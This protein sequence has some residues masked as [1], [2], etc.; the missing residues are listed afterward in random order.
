MAL[1]QNG[2]LQNQLPVHWRTGLQGCSRQA[3]GKGDSLNQSSTF[4]QLASTPDANAPPTTWIMPRKSGKISSRSLLLGAGG[5]TP[6]AMTEGRN[7]GA[8]LSG[9][10][11]MTGVA[12]LIISM[13]ASLT[14]NGVVIGAAQGFLQLAA[15]LAGSGNVSGSVKALANA[16]ASLDGQ[17]QLQST[18]KALGR[19][20]GSINVT[21]DVLTSANVA[22]SIWNALAV[23]FNQPGT[24]GE[25][26]LN[27]GSSGNPWDTAID[28]TYTAADVM[29]IVA[30]ALAG[31]ATG[32]GTP[33]ITLRN[34]SD[35]ADTIAMTVDVNGNRSA[36][37]LTP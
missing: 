34:L 15:S 24:M 28:G 23:S 4:G 5:V 8:G 1:L 26:V 32:G 31:K 6:F 3:Y 17:G 2:F 35:T 9:A 19:L 14:G 20:A 10:G 27:A 37:T 16:I 11:G 29:R 22:E 18:I 12:D 25:A 21:G 36:V 13:V 7:L 33:T 30:A